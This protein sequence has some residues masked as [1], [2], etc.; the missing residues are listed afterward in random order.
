[1]AF[2]NLYQRAYPTDE[3]LALAKQLWLSSLRRY[4][5]GLILQAAQKAIESSDFIP[6]IKSVLGFCQNQR[7]ALG[8]PDTRSAYV[9]AC[10]RPEPKVDQPW[11]HPAVY[12]AGRETGWF[13]LATEPEAEVLPVFEH[14]YEQLCERAMAGERLDL[15]LPRALPAE[16]PVR[17]SLEER[18]ARLA[19]LRREL[20]L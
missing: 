11:S 12:L 17:L 16:I 20:G 2:P 9:E 6:T 7:R 10:M 4:P 19:A 3:S 18:K 13:L 1:M 14:Y 5:P 8:L 15:P